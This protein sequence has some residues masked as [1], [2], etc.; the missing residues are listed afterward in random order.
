MLNIKEMAEKFGFVEEGSIENLSDDS[1]FDSESL[2][3]NYSVSPEDLNQLK[4]DEMDDE[5]QTSKA[6][7]RKRVPKSKTPEPKKREIQF[8]DKK[9]VAIEVGR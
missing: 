2:D 7:K 6:A 5:P 4:Y 8:E 3:A 1:Q 9:N